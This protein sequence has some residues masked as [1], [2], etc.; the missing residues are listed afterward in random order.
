M[1]LRLYFWR[2]VNATE[3]LAVLSF[4]PSLFSDPERLCGYTCQCQSGY[5]S[6]NNDGSFCEEID[7]CTE[8]YSFG[9]CGDQTDCQKTGPGTNDCGI[10]PCFSSICLSLVLHDVFAAHSGAVQCASRMRTSAI[11]TKILGSSTARVGSSHAGHRFHLG[12]K[13]CM[14][15]FSWVIFV[16]GGRPILQLHSF[17][18]LVGT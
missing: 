8:E 14:P 1:R 4:L 13:Q 5:Y 7:P 18:C 11:W 15:T 9:G 10:V 12:C 6:P 2:K 3:S 17:C 16:P